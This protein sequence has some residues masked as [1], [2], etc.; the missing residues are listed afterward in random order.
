MRIEGGDDRRASLGAG[1]RHRAADDR[2]VP[3][4]EAIEIPERDDR[5]PERKRNR[6]AAVQPLH[7]VAIGIG[8]GDAN[9]VR[10]SSAKRALK[11]LLLGG[12]VEV[13]GFQNESLVSVRHSPT[14]TQRQVGPPPRRT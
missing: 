1:T 5:I 13:E 10:E 7:G 6:R 9:G 14:P 12:G 11:P 4:M 2:L 3:E 8:R